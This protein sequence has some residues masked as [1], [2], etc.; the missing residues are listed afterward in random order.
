MRALAAKKRRSASLPF[1]SRQRSTTIHREERVRVTRFVPSS[2]GFSR[3]DFLR[4]LA[5]TAG[6]AGVER[7]YGAVPASSSYLFEEVPAETSRITWVHTATGA[8]SPVRGRC[9]PDRGRLVYSRR[10]PLG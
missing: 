8:R 6:F 7:R 1:S 4:T 2:P 10:S 3:R 9:V 5:G